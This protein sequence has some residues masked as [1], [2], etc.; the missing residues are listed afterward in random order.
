MVLV[1]LQ[2]MKS[3]LSE[4]ISK[5]NARVNHLILNP[6]GI[7]PSLQPY[8]DFGEFTL[9]TMEDHLDAEKPKRYPTIEEKCRMEGLY[10][11]LAKL[12]HSSGR[13][14]PFT[15][16]DHLF[17]AEFLSHFLRELHWDLSPAL[18]SEDQLNHLANVWNT[19]CKEEQAL[20]KKYQDCDLFDDLFG[21]TSP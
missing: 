12:L 7:V 5:V 16:D 15:E 19:R 2:N 4:E 21:S 14:A 17:F 6:P 11:D 20:T 3:S 10:F 9:P 1:A 13:C 8:E 18:Y